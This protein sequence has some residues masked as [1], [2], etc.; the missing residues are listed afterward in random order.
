MVQ[1]RIYLNYAIEILKTFFVVLLGLSIVALTVRAVNFLDL[2]VDNGYPVSTYFKYSFLNLSGIALKFI[3]FS[4]LLSLTIFAYKHIQDNEFLILWVSG[5]KKIHIVNLL[6]LCSI[7]ILILYLILSIIFTPYTLNKSR[8]LLGK[9]ELNSFLPTI[10]TQQFSDT[11]KGLTIIVEKKSKNELQNIFIYDNGNNLRNLSSNV[12]E[13][14]STTVIAKK[15]IVDNKIF[16]LL[17]G[18]IIS[19]KVNELKNEII[20]FDQLSIDLSDV[21]NTTIKNPKLQETAT[22]RLLSCIIPKIIDKDEICRE[23]AMGEII[24]ALNRRLVLPLYIPILSL[25]CSMLL[26][27]SNKRYLNKF[28]IFSY[29]FILLLYLE[30]II[31]FTGINNI[32]RIIFTFL[33]AILFLL[34]Y[35]Y[36]IHKFSK[37]HKKI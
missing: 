27:K 18:Q 33:P 16:F 3:P 6:F 30:I 37:E 7:I 31:R 26:I 2:I 10:K 34:L 20:N 13:L 4:F 17:N 19:S 36:L 12:S 5:V 15:G 9:E 22:H 21:S 25:I 24:P 28:F 8:Q 11:F 35:P 29:S 32:V 1:N 14:K 23:D